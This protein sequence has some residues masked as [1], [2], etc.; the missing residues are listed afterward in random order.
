MAKSKIKFFEL[1]NGKKNDIDEESV[2]LSKFGSY[3]SQKDENID[4]DEANSQIDKH[5]FAYLQTNPFK[6][7]EKQTEYIN[8]TIDDYIIKYKHKDVSFGEV[9]SSPKISLSRK[10]KIVKKTFKNWNNDFLKQKKESIVNLDT[11]IEL[12]KNLNYPKISFGK[13]ILSLIFIAIISLLIFLPPFIFTPLIAKVGFV[14]GI[15]QEI[16]NLYQ[17][18]VMVYY[19]GIASIVMCFIT[20]ICDLVYNSSCDSCSS[21]YKKYERKIKK[22]DQ[23]VEKNFKKKCKQ[24]LNYYLKHINRKN[25]P[26][27]PIKVSSIQLKTNIQ[28][29]D[30]I[31]KK[32]LLETANIKKRTQKIKK[33]DVFFRILSYIL[34]AT[35]LG[36]TIYY[37]VFF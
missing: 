4:V 20:F 17:T 14:E 21:N 37:I 7:D 31:N 23:E 22:S 15:I 35:Y 34:L 29:L 9:I 11:S 19:L 26:F 3:Q 18:K 1:S 6:Y 30:E 28:N 16:S 24:A 5:R 12:S 13:V 25:K 10:R 2:K 27:S 8:L 32:I 33:W 36:L